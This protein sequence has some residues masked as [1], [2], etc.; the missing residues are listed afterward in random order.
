MSSIIRRIGVV[1]SVAL[2]LAVTAVLARPSVAHATNYV[3]AYPTGPSCD[4][5]PSPQAC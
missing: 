4:S 2:A 1:G 3:V 5:P